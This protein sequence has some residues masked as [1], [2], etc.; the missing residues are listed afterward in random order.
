VSTWSCLHFRLPEA[1]WLGNSTDDELRS[2]MLNGP[3]PERHM[4]R[5]E[6]AA[7]SFPCPGCLNAN[8][9]HSRHWSALSL[10]IVIAL[11]VLC[12]VAGGGR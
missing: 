1:V 10:A 12:A 6:L 2:V 3:E 9:R 4:A 5:R 8:K 11:L 7:R